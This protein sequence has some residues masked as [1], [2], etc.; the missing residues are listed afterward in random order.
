VLKGQRTTVVSNQVLFFL[1]KEKEDRKL[2]KKELRDEGDSSGAGDVTCMER[3]RYN[4]CQ[5][6]GEQKK[7]KGAR[8]V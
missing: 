4:W 2:P 3:D 5:N 7:K 8:Q 1:E 6:D